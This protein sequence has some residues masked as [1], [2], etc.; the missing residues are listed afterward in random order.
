MKFLREHGE[1]IARKLNAE[2]R[3]GRKHDRVIVRHDGVWVAS[4]GLRRDKRATHNYIPGQIFVSPRQ[5]RDLVE[6]PLS[7]DGYYQ[8]LREKGKIDEQ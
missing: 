7:A 1:A 3:P 8:I 2:V 6:C 4:F 5:C